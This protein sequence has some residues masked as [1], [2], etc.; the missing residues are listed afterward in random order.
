MAQRDLGYTL[1]SA[2]MRNQENPAT[3]RIPSRDRREHVQP[4]DHVK[5]IFQTDEGAERMWVR[6]NKASGKSFTGHLVNEPISVPLQVGSLVRFRP[7]HICDIQR[8]ERRI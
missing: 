1:D 4:G 7:E 8:E 2:E 6:V 3:F 5:L